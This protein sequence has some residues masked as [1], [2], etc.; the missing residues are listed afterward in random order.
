MS[1]FNRLTP[2]LHDFLSRSTA[3]QLRLAY[4]IWIAARV[5]G[6]VA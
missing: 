1:D 4:D 3:A 6:G 5:S 2:A